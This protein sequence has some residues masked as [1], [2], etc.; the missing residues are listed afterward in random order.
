MDRTSFVYGNKHTMPTM[1]YDVPGFFQSITPTAVTF[2]KSVFDLDIWKD[3]GAAMKIRREFAEKSSLFAQEYCRVATTETVI[4]QAF[5][6]AN[7]PV[8]IDTKYEP[9]KQKWLSRLSSQKDLITAGQHKHLQLAASE[10][11]YLVLNDKAATL[12][13]DVTTKQK[14][15]LCL[16]YAIWRE[17]EDIKIISRDPAFNISEATLL[18]EQEDTIPK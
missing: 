12:N 5:D 17:T 13:V 6:W 11:I 16:N 4:I 10:L 9:V 14:L 1:A 2:I 7:S 18:Y 8:S 3:L 15:A